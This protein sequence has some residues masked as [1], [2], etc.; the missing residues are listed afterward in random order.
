MATRSSMPGSPL[1]RAL[2]RVLADGEASAV[3]AEATWRRY[4]AG[5]GFEVGQPE[6][7]A[8]DAECYGVDGGQ[9]AGLSFAVHS[10][11]HVWLALGAA[12]R[13][14]RHVAGVDGGQLLEPL[15][16]GEG[17]RFHKRLGRLLSGDHLDD[18]LVL[19]YGS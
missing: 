11:A 12:R 19:I 18:Q 10:A 5:C 1:V 7:D 9:S 6:T 13:A 14:E 3:A 2:H 15:L 16:S 8:V 17:A 4:Y